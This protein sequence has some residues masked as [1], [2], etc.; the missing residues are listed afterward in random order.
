[1]PGGKSP[2]RYSQE[3]KEQAVRRVIDNTLT[4]VQVARELDVN[5][6]TL[7]CWVTAYRKKASG[8]PLPAGM[9]ESEKM[10]ELERRNRELEMENAFLKKAAAYFAREH[11]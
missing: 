6:T 11:R 10:R 9:P 4:V 5:E 3:F 8:E 1:M 7:G 2:N